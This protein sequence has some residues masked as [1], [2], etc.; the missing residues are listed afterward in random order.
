MHT[1]F[2]IMNYFASNFYDTYTVLI[3]MN[4][5][6][7]SK[8]TGGDKE[9]YVGCPFDPRGTSLK[10]GQFLKKWRTNFA[11]KFFLLQ[12]ILNEIIQ[13]VVGRTFLV[14][15]VLSGY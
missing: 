2:S 5:E 4:I 6:E 3:G 15:S 9:V 11:P 12:T 8:S 14:L 10:K 13:M 7:C 1:N